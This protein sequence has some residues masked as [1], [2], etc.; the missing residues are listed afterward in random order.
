VLRV[1]GESHVIERAERNASIDNTARMAN[2]L[3]VEPWK[4]LK[5]D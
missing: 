5:D 3:Q 2:G 4:S 1:A